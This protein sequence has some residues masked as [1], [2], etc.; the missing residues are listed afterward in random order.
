VVIG[1][2]LTLKTAMDSSASTRWARRWTVGSP[3]RGRRAVCLAVRH[4]ATPTTVFVGLSEGGVSRSVDGGRS[5][6]TCR[7]IRARGS[8][9]PSATRRWGGLYA[10]HERAGCSEA[11]TAAKSLR[12]LD[13]LLECPRRTNWSFPPAA[14]DLAT[15][16]ME[17]TEPHEADLLL[18]GIEARRLM[19]STD[20]WAEWETTGR[21]ATWSPFSSVAPA[22]L[23][24]AAY[25]AGGVVAA[26]PQYRRRRDL[27]RPTP[28][29]IAATA[30]TG[31]LPVITMTADCGTVSASTGPR[32]AK[33]A[34]TRRRGIYRRRP[35]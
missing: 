9:S 10:G 15:L 26:P 34:A 11:T 16:T 8:R 19:R 13:A 22:T 4:G 23:R 14:V 7:L 3:V 6:S 29:S 20:R 25:E 27:R 31:P 21:R 28:A 1:A 24:G 5:G 12:E 30:T 18:V 2:P 33:F 17:R 35:R 32:R